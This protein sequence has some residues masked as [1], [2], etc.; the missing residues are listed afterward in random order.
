MP[1]SRT[2]KRRPPKSATS[3]SRCSRNNS[4]KR[5]T[6]AWPFTAW[7]AWAA[8]PSWS[9]W[10][11]WNSAWATR[12]PW[13]SSDR[14]DA[15]RSTPSSS[16]SSKSIDPRIDSSRATIPVPSCKRRRYLNSCFLTSPNLNK[17]KCIHTESKWTS[18]RSCFFFSCSLFI[19]SIFFAFFSFCLVFW[20][21]S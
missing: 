2:V 4:D 8:R 20:I 21:L 19:L 12:R 6:R 16:S 18:K 11:S 13:S 9:L 7:P 15:A 1:H 3:G 14:S 17:H 10:R 5:R